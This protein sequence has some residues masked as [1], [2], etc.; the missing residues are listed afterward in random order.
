MIAA[1]GTALPPHRVSQ[2]EAR[3]A[4]R[5]LFR[6]HPRRD[7]LLEIFDRAGVGDR[8]FCHPAAWYLEPRPF[9]ARNR[10]YV[11]HA[12]ALGGRAVR[13]ALDRAGWSARDVD[14]FWFTTTTG[15]ATPSLD[16]LL[17]MELGMRPDVQRTPL[18]GIG[19][20]GGAAGLGRTAQGLRGRALLLSVEL[21]GHTFRSGDGSTTNLVGAALFGDGAAA[22]LVEEGGAGPRIAAWG[23]ELFEGTRDVMGWDFTDDGFRLVLD[24]SVPEVVEARVAPALRRF[25]AARGLGLADIR[26]HVLHPGGAKV[27]AAYERALGVDVRWT[28]E[29]LRRIG[30]VSSAA[31]LFG[32]HDLLESGEA[33]KGDRGL[34]AAVGPGFALETALL[35]W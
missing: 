2:A 23:S 18:F 5:E 28:R 7:A 13:A 32:L 27:L 20:A 16:S 9:S 4:C 19:C 29:S 14:Q 24:A 8:H 30:N 15:L 3:E 12:T 1:T 33:R 6:G 22:V 11:E 17:A 31:V 34:V 21:C 10:D 35:E 25:L 26:H